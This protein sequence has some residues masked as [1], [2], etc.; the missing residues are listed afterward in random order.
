MG[1]MPILLLAGRLKSNQ[2]NL[3]YDQEQFFIELNE[4][5]DDFVEKL[6]EVAQAL[7]N[8]WFELRMSNQ[9]DQQHG[10]SN[11]IPLRKNGHRVGRNELCPC[12]SGKK[13]KKCCLIN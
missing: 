11:V 5:A 10:H 9:R 1:I 6:P 2:G 4:N 8:M 13:Y 12:G 3:N 7:H